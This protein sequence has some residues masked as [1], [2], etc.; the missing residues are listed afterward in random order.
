MANATPRPLYSRKRDLVLIVQQAGWAP[1]PVW[2][3]TENLASTGIRL[4]ARPARNE[5][6]YRLR[7]PGPYMLEVVS[8]KHYGHKVATMH[9]KIHILSRL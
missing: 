2:A 1:G 9:S 3:G 4:P 7:Y 5:M 6:L 8:F